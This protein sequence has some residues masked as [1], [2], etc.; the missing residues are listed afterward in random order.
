MKSQSAAELDAA[1]LQIPLTS[2]VDEGSFPLPLC[3]CGFVQHRVSLVVFSLSSMPGWHGTR[4]FFWSVWPRVFSDIA[5]CGCSY[6]CSSSQDSEEDGDED[7]EE[8]IK[9]DGEDSDEWDTE[10]EEEDGDMDAGNNN[11]SEAEAD[12]NDDDE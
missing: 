1:E 3:P 4:C 6:V 2:Y 7:Q 5:A 11:N 9:F 12:S 10:D 8:G